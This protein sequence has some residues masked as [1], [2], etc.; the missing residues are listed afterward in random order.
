MG[1]AVNRQQQDAERS[2]LA[3]RQPDGELADPQGWSHSPRLQLQRQQLQRLFGAQRAGFLPLQGAKLN[4]RKADGTI[5]GVSSFIHRPPSNLSFQGQ[6]L[7]AYVTFE[8]MVLSRVRDLRPIDAAGQLREVVLEILALPAMQGVNQWNS[9]VHVALG[10]IDA[11]LA[12]AQTMS[13]AD[14][15]K[16]VGAQIDGILRERNRV[17]GT[18]ISEH[19]TH[20]HGEATDAGSL[21]VMET[22]LRTGQ[23]AHYG[24]AQMAQ[25][26]SCLWRLF[27]YDPPDPGA[28]AAKRAKITKHVLTHVMSVRSAFPAVFDWLTGNNQYWLLPYLRAHRTSFTSLQRVSAANLLLIEQ[29]VHA[30]L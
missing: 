15:A 22:A 11:A 9:H 26:V 23:A 6:H 24:Q 17:P 8:Q 5:S 25:A 2:T 10:R 20:G 30:G 3:G 27:D 16:V 4:V 18:A 21:E 1:L 19:G 7:T 28:D 13:Q 14:A 12:G 29:Q